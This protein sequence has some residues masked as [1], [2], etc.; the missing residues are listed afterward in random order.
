MSVMKTVIYG[1][2]KV[3]F[4]NINKRDEQVLDL[5]VHV[6]HQ[7]ITDAVPLTASNR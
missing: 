4:Y 3:L 6:H 7:P 5:V 1:R 2:G